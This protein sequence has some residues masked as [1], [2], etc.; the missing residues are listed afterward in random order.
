MSGVIIRENTSSANNT[1]P[2]VSVIVPIY[3]VA[4]YLPSC[5]SSIAAQTFSDLE[6]LLIDDG[7][8]DDSSKIC[9][10]FVRNDSRFRYFRKNNGGLSE[11]RNTGVKA[12][13]GEYLFFLD[14]DDELPQDAIRSL[15]DKIEI[16]QAQVVIGGMN[17]IYPSHS[18]MKYERS[19]HIIGNANIMIY[20]MRH[21][22]PLVACNKLI[23]RDFLI[24]NNLFFIILHSFISLVCKYITL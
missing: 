14:S 16:D 19:N 5:L 20:S 10:C 23:R 17:W 3:N 15:V 9:D 24:D 1:D 4:E 6:V 22:F 7:S 11:A 8:T 21:T 18:E 2:T 12:S 13:N